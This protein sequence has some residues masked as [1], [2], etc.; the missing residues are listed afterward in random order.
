MTKINFLEQKA[1]WIRR[2]TLELHKFAPETRIASSLSPVEV[3]TTLYYGGFIK[4]DAS[5]PLWEQR[6]RVIISKGHGSISL[7]PILADLGFFSVCELERIGQEG[8]FLGGIPDPVIPGYE[9]VNG[10]LGHGPGVAA[11]M[12]IG[13]RAKNNP[14]KVF[15]LVGDGELYEGAVWEALMFSGHHRLNNLIL[16]IDAN[17][18]C[19]LDFCKNVIDYHPL[20]E[21][22]ESFRWRVAEVDG[23]SVAQL[24]DLFSTITTTTT[25][26]TTTDAAA[27]TARPLAIIAHT[28][29]GKGV[30]RLECDPLS[31]IK[32][33]AASEVD[34]LINSVQSG[35]IELT[36]K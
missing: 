33:L 12:A 25:P 15:V 35:Q 7:Y 32:T 9:T 5:N 13:L 6:D 11:G 23:H 36:E 30:P 8:S 18:A 26:I 21:K 1:Q 31:H 16:I 20:K 3:L 22:L 27:A 24:Y 10:S 17:K 2:R 34:A 4:F 28:I 19:M 14:A 29:K